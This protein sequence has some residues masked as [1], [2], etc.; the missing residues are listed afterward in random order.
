LVDAIYRSTEEGVIA[1]APIRNQN[2]QTIDFQ[3]VDLNAGAA[4]LLQQS[5]DELRWRRL[6][7]RSPAFKSAHI[8]NKLSKVIETGKHQ[9]FELTVAAP[10]DVVHL[11]VSAAPLGDLICAKLTDVTDLKRREHSSRLLFDNNP[12][13][14]WIFD[15]E[16]LNFLSVNDATIS[17]YGYSRDQLL[18]MD[19][20]Q[21]WPVDE[22]DPH[23]E[24]LTNLGE[25][26]QSG[27]SWR[28][29][30]ADGTEIE[31]LTFGRHVK[32]D[33]RDAY[34]VAVVDISEQKRAEAKATY[35]AY[36]DGLTGLPNRVLYHTQL[37]E[38]LAR[39]RPT[40]HTAILSID[41]DLFKNVNDSFGH[42][43]GDKLLRI[44][45]D[46]LKHALN[47]DDMVAR[48]GGDEFAITLNSI[49]SPEDLAQ[50]ADRLIDALKK[51]YNI[52]GLEIVIGASIGLAIA[53]T[54]GKTADDLL[55]N[56]DMALYRAKSEGRGMYHY[57]EKSMD[58]QVQKRRTM[59]ADLRKALSASELEVHYQPLVD[60][61]TG[62]VTSFES[63]LRW[64]HANDFISPS[65]FIPIAETTGL[66]GSIGEWVLRT[67]CREATN[68]PQEIG[69]AV[70]L[71]PAQFRDKNLV[72]IVIN[73][74]AG[75]GLSPSRLE[76]EI[77]ESVL[78]AETEANLS[79]LRQLKALGIRISMDD[80]GT[81]YSS[82]SYLRSFPF[83]K[84]K[85]DRSFVR[86]IVDKPDSLAII[87]A[88]STLG[89]SLGI[90]T[91]AE[92]V[93]TLEQFA[94]VKQEGCS[95]VQGYLFSAAK[96]ANEL[97]KLIASINGRKR[98]AA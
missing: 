66:I 80:F 12:L 45:A 72:S 69:V 4:H 5:I 50:I 31:V 65:E 79:T 53:P 58:E 40:E 2:E 87:R 73:A 6:S 46:R 84:I 83:D 63:L 7:E 61:E 64:R 51:P 9:T 95:E 19:T 20:K 29:I 30:K 89:R 74:L 48:L 18:S 41:L 90:R 25:S 28:H 57:F 36:H 94:S 78:L 43:M 70:N 77:T 60:A 3:I 21:L 13:P 98:K 35:L 54:D 49:A 23:L 14:M 44:V 81:G 92:G 34:L 96:P 26:Y 85:I 67:A 71:S 15:F 39:R 75:S 11:K 55:K 22:I 16:T 68:W 37:S 8:F 27:R 76:L 33:D 38:S 56:A 59:E 82:L 88:I 17:N 93:E 42:P 1:L 10:S 52:D 86:D 32:Y 47:K 24:A 97:A 91:T 62:R